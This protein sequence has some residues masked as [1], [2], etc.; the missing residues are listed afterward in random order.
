[1][2][3]KKVIKEKIKAILEEIKIDIAVDTDVSLDSTIE[4]RELW[5][6]F[7][8]E[9]KKV[10]DNPIKKSIDKKL[11]DADMGMWFKEVK[12]TPK[13]KAYL[14]N[15]PH[16][17]KMNNIMNLISKI[18]DNEAELKKQRLKTKQTTDNEMKKFNQSDMKIWDSSRELLGEENSEAN[19]LPAFS[20][21][22]VFYEVFND[23]NYDSYF[24]KID[25]KLRSKLNKLGFD[26][27]DY[28]HV[29][30]TI[31]PIDKKVSKSEFLKQNSHCKAK[32]LK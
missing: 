19:D 11:S 22:S 7:N 27:S 26:Y 29:D 20:V 32:Y 28:T 21:D 8:E 3:S 30:K 25:C 23:S 16:E 1:M 15:N 14:K 5:K 6:Q 31:I 12:Y 4:Q 17:K 2:V 10:K 18:S 9:E 13:E 24:K